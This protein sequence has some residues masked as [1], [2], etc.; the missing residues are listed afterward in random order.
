[1][2][3]QL[4]IHSTSDKAIKIK[5]FNVIKAGCGFLKLYDPKI[6]TRQYNSLIC[7]IQLG[8]KLNITRHPKYRLYASDNHS[9]LTNMISQINKQFPP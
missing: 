8:F 5:R 4:Y 3:K 9:L 7:Y 6:F 2:L 1:M